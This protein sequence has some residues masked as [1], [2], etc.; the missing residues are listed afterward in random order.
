VTLIADPENEADVAL[1][2]L[3]PKVE[4]PVPAITEIIPFGVTLWIRCPLVSAKKRFATVFIK[5][6]EATIFADVAGPSTP[7]E[8][9]VED[10]VPAYLLMSLVDAE[11]MRIAASLNEATYRFPAVS[12]VQTW[13]PF[14]N[15][16]VA[17]PP[18]P[19]L[20][21]KPVPA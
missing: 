15:A 18:S 7:V 4:L 19:E 11:T 6:L 3:P 20:P 12:T 1:P 10:P 17:F 21:C 5:A 9:T 14:C 8:P 13:G 16:L 2:R